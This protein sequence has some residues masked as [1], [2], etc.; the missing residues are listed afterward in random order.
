MAIDVKAWLEAFRLR[1]LPL[2]LS[3]I[4]MGTFLAA[5]KGYFKLDI[6]LLAVSTTV[7][8]QILSNLANDYGD[9]IHGADSVDRKGPSRAVQ[10]GSISKNEMKKAIIL[11]SVFSFISGIL[12][13]YV[14]FKEQ[15]IYLLIFLGIGL[16]SI[17]AAINYTAGSKPYGY[18]GL[19]DLAVLTFFGFVGVGGTYFLQTKSIDLVSLLP[20]LSCGLFATGVLNINNIR[21]IESDKGAG[22]ISIPVRL[23]REK[24]VIYHWI[25]LIIGFLAS[26]AFVLLNF[27]N[28]AEWIFL[29]TLPLFFV[30]AKAVYTKKEPHL[31]DPY[32]KQLS[33]TTLAFV[34]T[35]GFGL[36]I[37]N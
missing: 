24:A 31:L 9:S 33:L 21:D 25:I 29:V 35:F 15:M 7:L 6:F 22:K 30:N 18:R 4:L 17:F 20:A 19:G 27:G 5:D 2:S 3:C 14:T 12:L 34:I 11:F 37:S 26:V 10:K 23:G 32:L 16:A 28:I 13:L 1:T 36:L 8:L